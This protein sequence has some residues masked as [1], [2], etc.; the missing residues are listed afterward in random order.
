MKENIINAYYNF[1]LP[2]DDATVAV[3]KRRRLDN[4]IYFLRVL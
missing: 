2:N 1:Y 4:M 3:D